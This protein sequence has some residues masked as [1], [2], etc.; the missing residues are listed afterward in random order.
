MPADFQD[1]MAACLLSM[2]IA[3][4]LRPGARRQHGPAACRSAD[5]SE[6]ECGVGMGFDIALCRFNCESRMLDKLVVAAADVTCKLNILT[7][8]DWFAGVAGS[9]HLKCYGLPLGQAAHCF[10]ALK[11]RDLISRRKQ[12]AGAPQCCC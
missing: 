10:A 7:R 8:I 9:E 6:R 3:R 2:Q 12:L 11:Y 5:G 1:A 4:A